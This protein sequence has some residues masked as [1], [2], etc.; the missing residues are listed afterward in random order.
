MP[1]RF[2]IYLRMC[3]QSLDCTIRA[4]SLS[5][6]AID[7]IQRSIRASVHGGLGGGGAT[8]WAEAPENNV[9]VEQLEAVLLAAWQ[10]QWSVPS[11]FTSRRAPHPTQYR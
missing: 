4:G 3:H 11:G 6:T 9:H 5:N 7:L 1:S 10:P 2:S 8:V